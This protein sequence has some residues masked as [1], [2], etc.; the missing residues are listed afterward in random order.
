MQ[1]GGLGAYRY[2]SAQTI[3]CILFDEV[4]DSLCVASVVS[5]EGHAPPP[6]HTH[7]GQ[8]QAGSLH[9]VNHHHHD[10]KRT[11]VGLSSLLV[12]LLLFCMHV[13]LKAP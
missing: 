4:G 7:T 5:Q 3:R 8:Q 11:R 2:P 13:D 6:Q 12:L 9:A 10:V 1:S